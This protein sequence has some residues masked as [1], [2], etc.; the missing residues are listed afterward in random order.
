MQLLIISSKLITYAINSFKIKLLQKFLY[1][2]LRSHIFAKLSL[3]NNAASKLLHWT[4][5]YFKVFFN[6]K[7]GEYFFHFAILSEGTN[8]RNTKQP[9]FDSNIDT[10][11]STLYSRCSYGYF[12]S[13]YHNLRRE[14]FIM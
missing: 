11:R 9:F 10:W 6:F 5:Y 7:F 2:R 13:E 12:E 14:R 8:L 1:N 4:L 3:I